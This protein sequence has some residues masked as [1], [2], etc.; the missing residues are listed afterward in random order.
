MLLG[1]LLL[2]AVLLGSTHRSHA[3]HQ[4][5]YSW[6]T[7][8]AGAVLPEAQS[9]A[10]TAPAQKRGVL[11]A[12]FAAAW[13]R[14]AHRA[15]HLRPQT[16]PS[17]GCKPLG[18]HPVRACCETGSVPPP[19][20]PPPSQPNSDLL[21]SRLETLKSQCTSNRPSSGRLGEAACGMS[22]L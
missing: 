7:R 1:A 14:T 17:A 16:P 19:P 12:A 6:I 22:M 9:S 4:R 21:S 10:P 20:P 5:F 15:L 13:L 8:Q 3:A 18:P 2:G 11:R